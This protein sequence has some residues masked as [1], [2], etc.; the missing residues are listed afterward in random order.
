MNISEFNKFILF[1]LSG[2]TAGITEEEKEKFGQFISESKN[3]IY[4]RLFFEYTQIE[5]D[6]K[7]AR[8]F[9][10]NVIKNKRKME[11]ALGMEL[12]FRVAFLDY[13]I[14]NITTITEA[15]EP[16]IIEDKIFKNLNQLIVKD[17]LTGLFNYRHYENELIKE[18]ARAN[19][20]GHAFSLVIMDIDDFKLFNDTFGHLEG[21]MILKRIAHIIQYTV[22]VSDIPCRYGG[23]EFALVLPQTDKKGAYI[24]S[25]KIRQTVAEESFKIKVTISGG[26]AEFPGDTNKTD[27]T[28]FTYADK[29]LYHSKQKGKNLITRFEKNLLSLR[30]I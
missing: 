27:R 21:N 11:E 9:L 5:I 3:Y 2:K 10:K 12:D 20:H 4:A 24:L 28:L 22:R 30:S 26:I 13:L 7:S 14:R 8:I 19:R 23:E 18:F 25:E 15:S 1:Y 29:A 17:E 6:D 16:R